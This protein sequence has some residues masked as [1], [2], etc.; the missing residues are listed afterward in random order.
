MKLA[1][2][3]T[4]DFAVPT[5]K[6]LIE[7]RHEIALVI[8]QP[9][10]PKGRG[11]K[12]ADPPVKT[13]AERH[14]FAVEQPESLKK[15]ELGPKIRREGI[16][17][18]IVVAYGKI[19]PDALLASPRL[20][21]INLHAS[22]LPALRGAAPIQRALM[23]GCAQTGLSIQKMVAE[24]DAGPIIAQQV[25]KIHEDDDALSLSNHL[26]V[27]GA[28]MIVDVIGDIESSGMIEG[29]QQDEKLVT[30]AP[31]VKKEEG[32]ISWELGSM[33][34]MFRLRGLTP[35]PGLFMTIGTKRVRVVRAEPLSSGDAKTFKALE[36]APPGTVSALMKKRGP[37]IRTGDGHFLITRLQSEGKSVMEGEVFLRGA[38]LEVGQ[39]LEK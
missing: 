8:T 25:V 37:V 9:S 22:L 38:R 1:F 28:E 32:R 36:E 34:I 35:W 6:R 27:L 15:S 18:M 19:L 13:L 10:R 11:R 21:C 3:G 4:P 14:G 26:S 7:S 2:A 5:L 17:L 39:A 24:L 31:K 16:D 33:E 30:Y 23:E 20:G 29:E 12:I